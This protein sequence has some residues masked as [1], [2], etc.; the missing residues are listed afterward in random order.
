MELIRG[1]QRH[2]A[3]RGSLRLVW[4]RSAGCSPRHRQ[5]EFAK[6]VSNLASISRSALWHTLGP[7]YEPFLRSFPQACAP[8]PSGCTQTLEL[9]SRGVWGA[10]GSDPEATGYSQR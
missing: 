7:G 1:H 10:F 4:S 2:R 5:S 6:F 3:E 8:K 9:P